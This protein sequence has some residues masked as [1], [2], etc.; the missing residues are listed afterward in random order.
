MDTQRIQEQIEEISQ[1][2]N[3]PAALTSLCGL[4]LSAMENLKGEVSDRSFLKI[5]DET[6][7]GLKLQEERLRIATILDV[8]LAASFYYKKAHLWSFN[9][10]EYRTSFS[11]LL[12][13]GYNQLM[14]WYEVGGEEDYERVSYSDKL[15]DEFNRRMEKNINEYLNMYVMNNYA[16]KEYQN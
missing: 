13:E 6:C 4:Y 15:F 12:W 10:K 14:D 7:K 8:I 3:I 11:L 16:V 2:E 5:L 9:R 1:E